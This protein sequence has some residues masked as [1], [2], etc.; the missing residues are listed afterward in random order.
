M[1]RNMGTFYYAVCVC[2]IYNK[3]TRRQQNDLLNWNKKNK[4][5]FVSI[6][7]DTRER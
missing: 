6:T 7:R 5:I 3:Q 2:V 1:C 4:E